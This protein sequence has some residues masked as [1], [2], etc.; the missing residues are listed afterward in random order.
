MP[1]I[2]AAVA[3]NASFSPGLVDVAEMGNVG[4]RGQ[5]SQRIF[6]CPPT[7]SRNELST[8]KKA[9]GMVAVTCA[10]RNAHC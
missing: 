5:Q 10:A 1:A 8:S 7:W 6:H 4:A 9:E 3:I 2:P